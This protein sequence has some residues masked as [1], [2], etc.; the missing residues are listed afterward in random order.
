MEKVSKKELFG[1]SMGG[2][3][4]NLIYALFSGFLLFFYT[5]VFLLSPA[6]TGVLFLIVRI[7]D[8]VNDPIMGVI[9]DKTNT[10]LGHY[11]IYLLIGAP[12][13]ALSI[14][15][16]FSVINA[17]ELV[18]YIYCYVTYILLS[19]SFT[20]CDIPY[21]S[22]PSVMT[23]NSETRNKIFS[24]GSVAACLASGIGAV[25]IPIIVSSAPSMQEGYLLVA[26]IFSIIGIIGYYTCALLTKERLNLNRTSYSFKK[27]MRTIFKNKPL[28]ILMIASLFGNLAFQLKVATNTYYGQYALGNFDYITLLSAMLLIGMLIGSVIVPILVKK[29]GS[30]NAMCYTLISGV[31]IAIIYYLIGYSSLVLVLFI[32]VLSSVVIGAF[33]VLVNSLTA[34]TID[35]AELHLGQRNEGVITSTRTFMANF[36]TAIASAFVGFALELINYVPNVEQTSE[37]KEWLHIFMSLMPAGLYLIGLL[38]M[39]IYPLN[40]IKHKE[41]QDELQRRR[42]HE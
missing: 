13:V 42:S 40:N 36:S 6:F 1:Y 16:C 33:S 24:Y 38:I 27:A 11:R 4:H 18:K 22:L 28:V 37:V 23:S 31:V 26:I 12:I 3:G 29:F 32:S 34:D 39:I 8:A 17:S 5:D 10:K 14:L 41:L 20:M 7:F 9:A 2:V 15:L 30:K 19:A 35:Y 21:W 25:V